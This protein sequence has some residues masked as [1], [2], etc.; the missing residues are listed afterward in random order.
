MGKKRKLTESEEVVQGLYDVADTLR[1]GALFEELACLRRAWEYISRLEDY[2]D[3]TNDCLS[4]PS[5]DPYPWV[6]FEETGGLT[7][8][9]LATWTNWTLDGVS[10]GC[11]FIPHPDIHDEFALIWFV[12]DQDNVLD[13]SDAEIM[14]AK[15]LIKELDTWRDMSDCCNSEEDKD[16]IRKWVK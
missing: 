12:D 14:S 9:S 7:P 13:V 16:V 8:K 4:L 2:I 6:P 11:Y 5:G 1:G 15:R 3:Y 10:C